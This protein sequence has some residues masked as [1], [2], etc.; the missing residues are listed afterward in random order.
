MYATFNGHTVKVYQANGILERTIH[1]P[2][3]VIQASVSGNT[4]CIVCSNGYTYL[5]ETT[6]IEI[7]RFRN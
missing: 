5:Y 4:V 1:V 6:G 2:A 3:D 7:R